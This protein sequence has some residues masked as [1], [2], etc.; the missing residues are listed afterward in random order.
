MNRTAYVNTINS[1][2]IAAGVLL[3]LDLVGVLNAMERADALGPILDSTQRRLIRSALTLQAEVRR[4][5]DA[6]QLAVPA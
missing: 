5:F 6:K 2:Q 3:H 1:V 4:Q